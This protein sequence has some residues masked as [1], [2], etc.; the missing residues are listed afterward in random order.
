MRDAV[1]DAFPDYT[2][3][4]EGRVKCMYLDSEGVVSAGIGFALERAADALELAWL[5]DGLTPASPSDVTN[6]WRKVSGLPMRGQSWKDFLV[7][8]SLRAT[9]A[10]ID[11][12]FARKMARAELS[13]LGTFPT[14]AS[15]CADAQFASLS[16]CW[17][18]GNAWASAKFPHFASLAR[19]GAW[20]SAMCIDPS[21][22]RRFCEMKLPPNANMS[23]RSRAGDAVVMF[24]NAA[25]VAARDLDPSVLYWPRCLA[26]EPVTDA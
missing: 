5:V 16:Y 8:T 9:D 1:R 18:M 20:A 22:G 19:S 3:T 25:Q 6:E 24:G 4:R 15:W 7:V 12:L 11:D 17:A 10:S 14:W 13:M 21:T 26:E 2:V 23:L